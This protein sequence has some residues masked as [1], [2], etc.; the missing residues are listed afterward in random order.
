MPRHG[1]CREKKR[2]NHDGVGCYSNM[3]ARQCRAAAGQQQNGR[4]RGRKGRRD[5]KRGREEEERRSL[6]IMPFSGSPLR[7]GSVY[8][9]SGSISPRPRHRAAPRPRSGVHLASPLPR[10]IFPRQPSLQT[11]IFEHSYFSNADLFHSSDYLEIASRE[12]Y[13]HRSKWLLYK[14]NFIPDETRT[15]RNRVGERALFKIDAI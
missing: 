8:R 15:S 3:A 4:G 9:G 7:V 6:P 13:V 5:S 11:R 2:T 12:A 14:L 1:L 10:V